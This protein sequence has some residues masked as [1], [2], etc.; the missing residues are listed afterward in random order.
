ML[1]NGDG[2]ATREIQF[3][4]PL[5]FNKQ[6]S[7]SDDWN[8]TQVEVPPRG[9]ATSRTINNGPARDIS[10]CTLVSALNHA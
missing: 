1:P 2:I 4:P 3:F 6:F 10:V 8:W 9:R 7:P 5:N